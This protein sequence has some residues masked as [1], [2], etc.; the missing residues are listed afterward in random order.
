ML[1]IVFWAML[2][3]SGEDPGLRNFLS[4]LTCPRQTGHLFVQ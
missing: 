2:D 3:A 1:L 4:K